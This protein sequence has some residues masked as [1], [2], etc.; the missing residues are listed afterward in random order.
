MASGLHPKRPRIEEEHNEDDLNEDLTES[1]CSSNS[2]ASLLSDSFTSE[3]SES[4]CVSI[5]DEDECEAS[6]FGDYPLYPGAK[7]TVADTHLRLLNFGLKHALTNS[8]FNDLL[9]L[10]KGILPTGALSPNNY[11][12]LKHFFSNTYG[13]IKDRNQNYC[14]KCHRL[15]QTDG[16]QTS[17]CCSAKV[18]K[19]IIL[20][21]AQQLKRIM[22]D[23]FLWR[24]MKQRFSRTQSNGVMCDI[25]DGEEYIKHSCP[26]EFL[27]SSF[28][29]NVSFIMN[30]DGVAIFRSSKVS[31]WPIWLVV[32][33]LP[34][35]LR[36]SKSHMLLAGLWYA[37]EK[38]TMTSF[39]RPLVEEI[40]ILHKE[41]ILVNTPDGPL[42]S[43]AILLC[44]TLDLPA[45]A[46]VANMKQWNGEYGCSVCLD[47]GDNTVCS[48][49]RSWGSNPDNILRTHN[50]IL[51]DA[52]GSLT[53][54]K[55]VNGVKGISILA[56][57]K[58]FDLV[59][60]VAIDSMH[61]VFLRVVLSLLTM[62]FSTEHKNKNYSLR[63]K[64]AFC[65]QRL[66][67]IKIPDTITR[68]PKRLEEASKWKASEL[69]AW[70]FYF[71]I[72]VLQGVLPLPYMKHFSLLVV[73][74]YILSKENVT[75]NDIKMAEE[76]LKSFHAEYGHLYGHS[77]VTMS[78]HLLSHLTNYVKYWGPLWTFS[79]FAFEGMN[80]HLKKLFHG[81][82]D[83]SYNLALSFSMVQM[84][85]TLLLQTTKT[86]SSS[87]KHQLKLLGKPF[88]TVLAEREW[89]MLC[90]LMEHNDLAAVTPNTTVE[91]YYR[92][93][94]G[95]EVYYSA[96]YR[97]L[98]KRNSTVVQYQCSNNFGVV[99]HFI[100]F[101]DQ[102]FAT[103]CPFQHSTQISE[104]LE[105]PRYEALNLYEKE[106]L[107]SVVE[108]D[109]LVVI[110][111]TDIVCKCI[112]VEVDN[113]KYVGKM[114]NSLKID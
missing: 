37:E 109:D 5:D 51:Q 43:C 57:H 86:Q 52:R 99:Q 83:M 8:A 31:M 75:V 107:H 81:T 47:P 33:E 78:V 88:R 16:V 92:V 70:L 64:I 108:S 110:F 10:V 114:P 100:N 36:F 1:V 35:E 93:S 96:S 101:N 62:W 30:T 26:G 53:S 28:P 27:S 25:Y 50:G 71:A 60:G 40:S 17:Q 63:R 66:L 76:M 7:V 44:T 87:H 42:R 20:P 89:E 48:T 102:I 23:P 72:P 24:A 19:F 11:Y 41:G 3:C 55:P 49:S 29:A 73:G 82:R 39:L 2:N 34:P 105:L 9:R 95:E 69:R 65:N 79:A 59:K 98:L 103:V 38:P 61:A 46:S 94:K 91:L 113:Y 6:A 21:V 58:P 15:I 74:V 4:E 112:L 14:S 67:S 90:Q 77:K 45:K 56:L 106:A 84:I 104:I 111:V 18:G 54:K 97:R 80:R 22:E 85:P 13:E 32:N 12:A 68:T